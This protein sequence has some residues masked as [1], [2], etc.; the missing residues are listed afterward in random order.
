M[1][2]RGNFEILYPEH[3]RDAEIYN[4]LMQRTSISL[5]RSKDNTICTLNSSMINFHYFH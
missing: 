4:I 1:I 3:E 2:L 5:R